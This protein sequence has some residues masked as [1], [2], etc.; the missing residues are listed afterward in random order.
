MILRYGSCL[1]VDESIPE[2]FAKKWWI[3]CQ[4]QKPI[5]LTH[6]EFL[7]EIIFEWN[8]EDERTYTEEMH[9]EL[10]L[11]KLMAEFRKKL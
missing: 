9:K 11:N 10:I 1:A 4:I 8:E 7:R 6:A 5:H 3:E 2:K